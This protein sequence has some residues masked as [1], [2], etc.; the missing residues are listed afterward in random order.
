MPS[1]PGLN[2]THRATCARKRAAEGYRTE[3]KDLEVNEDRLFDRF[4]SKIERARTN[5]EKL[6]KT[7]N[8]EQEKYLVTECVLELANTA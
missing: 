5:V 1:R 3:M 6:R 2:E 4:D 7:D 8:V